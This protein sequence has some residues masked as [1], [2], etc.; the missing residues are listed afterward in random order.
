MRSILG[1]HLR[2]GAF[3]V[4]QNNNEGQKLSLNI[5]YSYS[6]HMVVSRHHLITPYLSC[7]KVSKKTFYGAAL[8]L[9][10]RQ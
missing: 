8:F 6:Q 7:I 4:S 5:R 9:E 1:L 3:T 10:L 2:I